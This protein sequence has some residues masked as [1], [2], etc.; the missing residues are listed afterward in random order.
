MS[1]L[2][3]ISIVFLFSLPAA[4]AA[5][6]YPRHC[7]N[8]TNTAIATSTPEPFVLPEP[9]EDPGTSLHSKQEYTY[10]ILILPSLPVFIRPDF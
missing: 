9:T 7:T 5:P 2:Q 3:I 1:V 4:Q 10:H 6:V 8:N